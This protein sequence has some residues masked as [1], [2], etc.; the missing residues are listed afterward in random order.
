MFG[1][2]EVFL[3]QLAALAHIHFPSARL[4]T[5]YCRTEMASLRLII[6]PRLFV[7]IYYNTLTG[8]FDFS[9]IQGTSRIFGYDN[10]KIWHFHP[11]D[12]PNDHVECIAPT[13]EQILV[14]T[15]EVIELLA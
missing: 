3:A 5:I 2:L 10:L 7:D 1:S 13:L 11:F 9:L 14:E 4:E 8:R 15:S 12:H 6:S